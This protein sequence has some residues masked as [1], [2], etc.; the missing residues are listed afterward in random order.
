MKR[1]PDAVVFDFDG[2][3]FDSETSIYEASS[4]ALA[5][6]GH[7]MSVGMW[8]KLIGIGGDESFARMTELLDA[9]IDPDAYDRA[10]AAEERRLDGPALPGVVDLLEA[11]GEVD[12]PCGIASSSS[13]DWVT[14]HLDRLGL[15]ACF[16]TVATRDRVGGRSKPAPDSYLLACSDLGAEPARSVALEDSAPG[17]AAALAARMAVVAVPSHITVHTDLSGAHL[18]VASLVDVSLEELAHLSDPTHPARSVA[19]GASP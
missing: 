2:L 11:L 17:V 19:T 16:A 1:L 5:T 18:S 10:Y 7:E 3:I 9:E 8:A 12:V 15:T 14:G 4:A 6:F 13:V